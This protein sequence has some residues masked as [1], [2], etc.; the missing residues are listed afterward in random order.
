[1]AREQ[2]VQ[3]LIDQVVRWRPRLSRNAGTCHLRWDGRVRYGSR[4]HYYHFL[5]GYLLPALHL[6]AVRDRRERYVFETCGPVMDPL[7]DEAMTLAGIASWEIVPE[8]ATAKGPAVTV[9]RWDV[10][11]LRDHLLGDDPAA[12]PGIVAMRGDLQRH[13]ERR[14]ELESVEAIDRLVED[15]R[16]V[17]ASLLEAAGVQHAHTDGATRSA[18]L[19]L[20]RSE[21]PGFYAPGGPAEI[22]GYGTSRR[23]LRGIDDGAAW[24]AAQGFEVQ[25]FEPGAH[26]LRDQIVAFG[27]SA[28]AIGIAGAEFANAVW[29]PPGSRIVVIRPTTMEHPALSR[30]VAA[31][32]GIEY[33]SLAEESAT[34]EFDPAAVAPHLALASA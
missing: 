4:E 23:S 15:L 21:Q 30:L 32:L 19:L 29:L 33:V 5:L 27:T 13:P 25:T 16:A 8:L 3:R 34:P 11:L 1:M 28:G 12:H 9:P 6:I 2:G 26:S 18:Y 7:I 24:L 22:P 31:H 20:V 10:G 17:R 14:A